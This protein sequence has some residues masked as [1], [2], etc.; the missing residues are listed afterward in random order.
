VVAVAVDS[1]IETAA[2][3]AVAA[4]TKQFQKITHKSSKP[5]SVFNC[6]SENGH[7]C[8]GWPFPK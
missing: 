3:V 6:S 7:P 2:A 5:F 4:D 8:L 1:E